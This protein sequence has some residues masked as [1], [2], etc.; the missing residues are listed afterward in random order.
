MK[1]MFYSL[2]ELQQSCPE[3]FFR[4]ENVTYKIEMY[5]PNFNMFKGGKF[6]KKLWCWVIRGYNNLNWFINW[7]GNKIG[8]CIEFLLCWKRKYITG[9]F[10]PN[11]NMF[12]RGKFIKKTCGAASSGGIT[13]QIS[14]IN[15]VDDVNWPPQRVSETDF[16]ASALETLYSSQF[17]LS[18]QMTKPNWILTSSSGFWLNW[19]WDQQEK[20][21]TY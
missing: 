15:Q 2:S 12:K 13:I 17:T 4:D 3:P 5:K 18:T 20:E 11:F 21:K 19:I 10:K 7:V 6:L 14:F 16:Q 9:I 1:K 8:H